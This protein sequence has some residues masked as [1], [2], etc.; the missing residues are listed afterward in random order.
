MNSAASE[1]LPAPSARSAFT[2]IGLIGLAHGTSHFFHMLLP[3]LFP[4]F[5]REFGFSYSELGLLVTLFFTISGIGQATAGFVVDRIGA[6]PVLFAALG[7]FVAAGLAAALAQ[8]YTGL[9]LAAALAGLATRRSTPPISPSSTSGSRH[10]A[11]ATRSRSMA[12]PA[13]WAGRWRRCS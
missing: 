13:T 4:A 2:T 11:S 9:M 6:R 12:S 8:G 5:I 3:P 7:C 1:R 10:T